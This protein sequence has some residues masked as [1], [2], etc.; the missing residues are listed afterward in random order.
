MAARSMEG[1]SLRVPP[2][3]PKGVRTALTTTTLF[4]SIVPPSSLTPAYRQ[5]GFLS[6]LSDCATIEKNR[7]FGK[8]VGDGVNYLIGY[9]D[10][11]KVST[12][13]ID[14]RGTYSMVRKQ[15]AKNF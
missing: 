5:V 2:N 6:P 3:F 11:A 8:E 10:F 14:K 9:N 4:F 15:S 7:F 13:K 1:T 12:Y